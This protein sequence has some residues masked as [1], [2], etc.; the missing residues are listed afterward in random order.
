[1][2]PRVRV[3]GRAQAPAGQD[4]AYSAL[5]QLLAEITYERVLDE[6]RAII[7]DPDDCVRQLEYIRA[8]F[9]EVYPTFQINFGMMERARAQRSLELFARHVMPHFR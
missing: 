2:A 4:K 6:T 3:F 9:G 5:E 1:M 8:T 7:G